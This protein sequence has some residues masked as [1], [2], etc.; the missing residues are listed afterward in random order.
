[1]WPIAY[2]DVNLLGKAEVKGVGRSEEFAAAVQRGT[3]GL[4]ILLQLV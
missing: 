1:M 2:A 4:L 3:F